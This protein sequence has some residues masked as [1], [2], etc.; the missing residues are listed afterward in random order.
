M[1]EELDDE[2]VTEAKKLIPTFEHYMNFASQEV[3]LA[4]RAATVEKNYQ[5]I[6]M[7]TAASLTMISSLLKKVLGSILV[8]GLPE[9]QWNEF[10]DERRS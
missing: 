2:D 5:K 10:V 1:A 3:G 4:M 7:I 6:N 9:K 8:F